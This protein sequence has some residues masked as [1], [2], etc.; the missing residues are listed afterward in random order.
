[1]RLTLLAWTLL[2]TPGFQTPQSE[3]LQAPASV[4]GYVVRLGTGLPL[5][6]TRVRVTGLDPGRGQS[7]EATTDVSGRFVIPNVSPGRYRIL[8]T[9]DGYVAA[10]FG[11]RGLNR[12]GAPVTLLPG[13]QTGDFVITMTPKG[14]I[15]GRVYDRLGE[16]VVNGT[17]RVFRHTYL[18][19]QR[20][21][22]EIERGKTN[23]LGDYRIFWLDPGSYVL[24]AMP[25]EGRRSE[26]T[27]V[28]LDRPGG[29]LRIRRG[30]DGVESRLVVSR[31]TDPTY[32]PV[33]YPGTTEASEALPIELRPGVD[34]T[35][36]DVLITDRR[37]VRVT[38]QVIN[39][40]RGETSD[41]SVMLLP[42][43]V[44]A[45]G[46]Q[47][48]RNARTSAEG[49]FEFE[50]VVPG[51]Y[52]VAVIQISMNGRLLGFSRGVPVPGQ[53]IQSPRLFARTSIEVGKDD[54]EDIA[55]VLQPSLNLEG[56]LLIEGSRGME[57]VRVELRPEPH[58]PMISPQPANVGVGGAFTLTGVIPGT[59]RLRVTGTPRTAYIKSARLRAAD[60]L[61]LGMRIDGD[62]GGRLEI[63]IGLNSGTFNGIVVDERRQPMPDV[64][65]VLVPDLPRRQRF[66]LYRAVLTDESGRVNIEGVVPG[67]YQVFVWDGVQNNIWQD[68][69]F[70]RRHENY[71]ERI[72][73]GEGDTL[74][75]SL[76]VIPAGI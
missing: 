13:S 75:L 5:A 69:D 28:A 38:G 19:G 29:P 22:I 50:G 30:G 63:V 14:A 41:F 58:V 45:G 43:G 57:G 37:A 3:P 8:A 56:Q 6:R 21:L 61:D 64:R 26:F 2:L 40:M 54:I 48:R 18:E 1:M 32:L 36:V 12:P 52:D 35:G 16:P 15:S 70:I 73:M 59:Y 20:V 76:K 62:P 60:V 71:G 27:S 7:F 65:V 33:Y 24:S 11:Q 17:V 67:N 66:E 46:L 4:E 51:S 31:D 23:D 39:G 10:Q 68:P 9:R 72:R 55:L 42:R 53:D 25:S 47:T 49:V 74:N 44:A 34:S